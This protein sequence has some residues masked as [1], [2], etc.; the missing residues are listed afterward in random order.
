MERHGGPANFGQLAMGLISGAAVFLL[1]F[2]VGRLQHVLPPELSAAAY[3]AVTGGAFGFLYSLTGE[4]VLRSSGIGFG[5]GAGMLIAS[6]YM[7]YT[8]Q[9]RARERHGGRPGGRPA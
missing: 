3:G 1:S 2:T 7:L 4:S 9:D 8:R 6:F 5:I